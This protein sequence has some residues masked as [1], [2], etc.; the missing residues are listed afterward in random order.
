[1]VKPAS[2]GGLATP[3]GVYMTD[4]RHQAGPGNL[5]LITTGLALGGIA[6]L[7]Q[8][9]TFVVSGFAKMPESV[10][11]FIQLALFIIILR[12]TPLAKYHAAEHQTIHAI[13]KGLPLTP[14][15]VS[16]M[17][18]AHR[19]CGTNIMI[20]TTGILF[21]VILSSDLLKIGGPV[22]QFVFLTAGFIFIFSNCRRIGMWVQDNFTTVNA[23]EKQFKSSIKAGEELLDKHKNDINP[24]PPGFLE[25]IWN[26]GIIQ[27]LLSFLLLLWIFDVIIYHL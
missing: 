20:L 12:F 11:L 10:Y 22:L 24:R 23:S 6:I 18:R 19:R 16:M 15:T 7:V 27:I 26:M 21:V 4:G 2:I 3:L 14:E 8:L 1:M 25:K 9:I 13:E 5:G 17:P